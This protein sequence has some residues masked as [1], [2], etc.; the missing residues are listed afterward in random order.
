MAKFIRRS[1]RTASDDDRSSVSVVIRPPLSESAVIPH[2]AEIAGYRIGPQLGRGGMGVVYK[3]HHMRLD[4]AA[5]VKVLT[6][7]LAHNAEFRE[8]FIRESQMAATLQHP[9]VITVYDAG[10]DQDLLYL[11]M[12][13]VA[14]THLRRLLELEGPPGAARPPHAPRQGGGGPPP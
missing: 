6:P 13:F 9:N 3:A 1:G 4:R 5:A 8:R 7:A 2:G 14:G 10:E 11:A 12:Q